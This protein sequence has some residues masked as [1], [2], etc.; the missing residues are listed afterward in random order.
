[1]RGETVFNA[2]FSIIE[3]ESSSEYVVNTNDVP[4]NTKS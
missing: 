4:L 3:P 2:P 1:M